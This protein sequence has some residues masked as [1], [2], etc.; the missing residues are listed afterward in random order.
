MQ[1]RDA[2]IA[3]G[4]SATELA[5]RAGMSTAFV[6]LIESG[7]SGSAE[8]A[9]RLATALGHQVEI[10]LVDP[11]RA[12]TGR[13]DL[14]VDFVHSAIGEFEA[15]RLR[16]IGFPVGMDEPYQHYQYAGRADLV[17]W[18][19]EQRALLHIENRTRFP[20]VQDTAGVY[21]AKRAYLGESLAARL[22]IARW[23]SETHVLAGLWSWEVLHAVRQRPET[24]RAL[25]PAPV[26][27]FSRWWDGSLATPERS[28]VFVVLDPLANGRQRAFVGLDEALTVRARYRGYADASEAIRR[29]A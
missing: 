12:T 11:K 2:R 17:A 25:C 5:K 10:D 28:S 29:S 24:F 18:D 26:E 9:V 15:G 4:W 8:A 13:T 1:V 16:Q 7:R 6:Y 19:L 23:A 20:D 22:G 27:A 14:S 21:N 3:R